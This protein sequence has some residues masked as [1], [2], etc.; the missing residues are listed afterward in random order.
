MKN[1]ASITLLLIA[2]FVSAV[3][4][5]ISMISIPW[6]FAKDGQMETFGLVYIVGNVLALFWAP[7]SGTFTDRYSRKTILMV[8]MGFL[9]T[10]L[11]LVGYYGVMNDGLPW[12]FVALIFVLTFLNYNLHYP[13]LYAFVQEMSEPE[14]YGRISSIIEVQ[15][16]LATISAGAGAALL[17]EGTMSGTV[18]GLTLPSFLITEPWMIE[19][20]FLLDAATYA[21]GI[22][23]LSLIS[24]RSLPGVKATGKNVIRQLQVGLDYLKNH[25]FVI[26]FGLASYAVFVAVIIEGFYLLA[27]Y[28]QNALNST[29]EVYAMGEMT[30]AAGAIFAG[31]TIRWLFKKLTLTDSVII[32]VFI[33]ASVFFVMYVN[34]NIFIFYVVSVFLGLANAGVRIQ[35]V[36]YLFKKVENEFYG[37]VNS[38]FNLCNILCRI[39][40]LSLFA[41][42]FFHVSDHIVYPFLILSIFVFCCLGVLLYHRKNLI[43]H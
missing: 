10:A 39:L 22:G 32:L 16:Q 13:T 17:L 42:P 15:G 38:I 4:Q 41:L 1:R 9:G 3:S 20:I 35:R 28:V 36:T 23:V 14:H 30:Y 19:E 26:I 43:I 37:R 25:R 2:N 27:P 34:R 6:F 12:Y 7:V 40:F 31:F 21:L 24:F 8:L 11:F 29:G 5:G 18:F 33:A